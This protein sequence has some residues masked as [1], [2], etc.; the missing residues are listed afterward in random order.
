MDLE[1]A[2]QGAGERGETQTAAIEQLVRREA[3]L[4]AAVAEAVAVRAAIE[5]R[6]TDAE[7]AGQHVEQRAAEDLAAAGERYAIL[8]DHL[9]R[10]TAVR[11]ALEERLAAAE[12]AR[13]DDHR[14]HGLELAALTA[15]LGEREARHEAAS[16]R[17]GRICTALQQRLLELEAAIHTADERHAADT[18]AV[19]RLALRERELAT[20]M[21]DGLAVRT[22]L[23]HR[24]SE[25][26]AAYQ[27]VAVDLTVVAQRCSAFEDQATRETTTRVMLE[28]RLDAAE[29]ARLEADR[30]H[31]TAL[32]SL[33]T[34]LADLQAQRDT[35][36]SRNAALERQLHESAVALEQARRDWRSEVAT[37]TR[38]AA[39]AREGVRGVRGRDARRPCRTRARVG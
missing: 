31:A 28:Q 33:T 7:A 8:E 20:A 26:D 18:A 3:E 1:A 10:E 14:E 30:Q 19:E 35:T 34:R 13:E 38:A 17:I 4:S 23:E 21:A 25:R 9:V 22:A 36:T 12:H 27:R 32:A 5:R 2:L 37:L 16:A 6:L 15:R 29:G 39:A 24:L 11:T